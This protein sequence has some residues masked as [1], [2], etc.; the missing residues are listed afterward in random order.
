M[1]FFLLIIHNIL[2]I[3]FYIPYWTKTNWD[4]FYIIRRQMKKGGWGQYFVFFSPSFLT[5]VRRYQFRFLHTQSK[6]VRSFSYINDT[7]LP[8]HTLS[9]II[10]SIKT[11]FYLTERIFL[12]NKSIRNDCRN[13]KSRTTTDAI[14]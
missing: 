3:L 14:Q 7:H 10:L 8:E 13:M 11:V 2:Y 9:L 12:Y 1:C 4:T 5:R 6:I